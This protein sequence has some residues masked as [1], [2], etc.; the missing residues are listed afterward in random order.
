MGMLI[1]NSRLG[2]KFLKEEIV[3]CIQ[4]CRE[5]KGPRKS[6]QPLCLL[7]SFFILCFRPGL[8]AF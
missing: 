7:S 5:K 8:F 3:I 1:G 4:S 6:S 2:A